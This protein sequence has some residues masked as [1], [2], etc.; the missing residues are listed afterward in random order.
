MK[1]IIL[2]TLMIISKYFDNSFKMGVPT[3]GSN[4]VEGSKKIKDESS[5]KKGDGCKQHSRRNCLIV[6]YIEVQEKKNNAAIVL[7][8]FREKL[9]DTTS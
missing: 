2:N 6:H 1:V 8:V 4:P 3:S 5:G 9:L 7:N